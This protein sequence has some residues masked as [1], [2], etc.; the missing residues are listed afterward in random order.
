MV[1]PAGLTPYMMAQRDIEFRM[2]DR[3]GY[4]AAQLAQRFNITE[5]SVSRWRTR[6]GINHRPPA[7]PYP[8]TMHEAAER[9]LD[10][11]C[12]FH[13]AAR[14]LG[15]SSTTLYRW[16]PDRP[17]WSTQQCSEFAVLVRMF[18]EVA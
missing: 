18:G 15:I 11:G 13:E 17:R 6:L 8:E 2:C 3:A 9:L 1:R 5:R 12:S 16:F 10:D 4:T 7:T 14:T